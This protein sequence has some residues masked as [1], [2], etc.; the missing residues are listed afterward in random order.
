MQAVILAAGEG[1]RLR[2]L[3]V[4]RPKPLIEFA[5]TTSL[6]YNLSQ[7]RGLVSEVIIIIGYKGE[8]IKEKIGDNYKGLKI[9]YVWQEKQ[10]G[11]GDAIKKAAPLIKKEFLVLNGDDIYDGVDFKRC[12]KKLPCILIKEAQD[13][14]NL[15]QV[16]L[17][18]N[19]V[20]DIIEKPPKIIS[21]F[22]Y[23]GVA[24]FDKSI[25]NYQIKMSERGEYEI[26]DYIKEIAKNQQLYWVKTKNWYPITAPWDIIKV[27]DLF[28]EKKRSKNEGNI[29][30]NVVLKGNVVL[31]KNVRV[32]SGSYIEGSILIREG[33]TIGPNSYIR[34]S[35]TIGKNCR[36]GAA[37]EIKNSV[38]GNNTHIS[39]LAYVGDSVI[40]DNVNIAA[41]FIAANLRHDGNSVKSMVK[42][43]LVDTKLRKFGC[44]IGDNVKTGIGTLVYPGRKIWPDKFTIPGEIIKE[45]KM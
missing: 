29:E 30:K 26:T 19:V 17:K 34:G 21:H 11:T 8:M 22:G 14:S 27:N 35:T 28:L 13:P 5:G 39:H 6:E 10:L 20:K 2:P 37:V 45:D 4:N 15:G 36:I 24:L 7:L 44:V 38:I 3:T 32:L 31:E 25:F 23:I 12:S 40:G 18:G 42:N 16:I 9:K 43:V 41:G 1:T 33:S